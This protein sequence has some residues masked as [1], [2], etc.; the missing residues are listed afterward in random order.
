MGG[1]GG[2]LGGGML[3]G[4]LG[5]GLGNLL[6]RFNQNGHGDV[7]QSW[8]GSGPNQQISPDQLENAL[9]PEDIDELSRETGMDRSE[10]L[11]EL[12]HSLPQV[13]DGLTPHGRLPEQHEEGQ[14]V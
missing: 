9:G 4:M 6:E 8:I 7:M 5:G 12:S 13:V 2:A 3:G 11:S 10:L 14:W 1:L